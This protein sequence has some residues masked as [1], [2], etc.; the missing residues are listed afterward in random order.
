MQTALTLDPTNPDI[1]RKAASLAKALGRPDT[2][3]AIQEYVAARDP[4]NSSIHHNLGISYYFSGRLDEAIASCRTAL[5]LSPGSI[6]T[7]S[8]LGDA[9]LVQGDAEAALQE[10]EQEPNEMFRLIGLP[11]A[12]HALGRPGDADTALAELI[13]KCAEEAAYN[14]AY[15]MAYRRETDQ[16]FEWLDK[17]VEH[18]DP[19]L[20]ESVTQP[21]FTTV[22]RDPRWEAFLTRIGM[23]KA[24]LDAIEFDVKL[25][26]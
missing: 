19:G 13:E 12:Y 14:I 4:V 5:R 6:G 25:P 9:L 26:S 3:I 11:I 1:L 2:A 7:H 17:A 8:I 20:Q 21:L 22:H 24:Q 18:H 15:V 16:A 10:I 23:S